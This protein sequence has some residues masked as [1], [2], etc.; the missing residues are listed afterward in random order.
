MSFL[1]AQ[2]RVEIETRIAYNMDLPMYLDGNTF[3]QNCI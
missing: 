2:C 1:G 3:G